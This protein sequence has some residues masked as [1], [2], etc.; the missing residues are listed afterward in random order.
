MK[1]STADTFI[2]NRSRLSCQG[3]FLLQFLHERAK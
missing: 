3:Y 2:A 1:Q